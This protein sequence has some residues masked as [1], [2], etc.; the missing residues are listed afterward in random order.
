MQSQ[1]ACQSPGQDV[2]LQDEDNSIP[3]D[4]DSDAESAGPAGE[5]PKHGARK[6]SKAA[7]AQRA[8][9]QQRHYWEGALPAHAGLAPTLAVNPVSLGMIEVPCALPAAATVAGQT[10]SAH[11]LDVSETL[12]QSSQRQPTY[13]RR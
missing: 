6:M 5:K 11:T 10:N 8:R 4:L 3:M 2:R 13:P 1:D 12:V 9:R 7:R